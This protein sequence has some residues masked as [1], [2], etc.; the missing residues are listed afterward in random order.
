MLRVVHRELNGAAVVGLNTGFR[1][2]RAPPAAGF[3]WNLAPLPETTA[4][5]RSN[6]LS[7]PAAGFRSNLAPPAAGFRSNLAPPAAG[8]R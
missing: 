5:F 3:R 4:G 1:S 2:T 6:R 7:L 8:L